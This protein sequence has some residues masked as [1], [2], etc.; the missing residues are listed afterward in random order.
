MRKSEWRDVG[1]LDLKTV[2]YISATLLGIAII[3]FVIASFTYAR[4][5][6]N[7]QVG[8]LKTNIVEEANKISEEKEKIYVDIEDL[9]DENK[10]E[11]EKKV[12]VNTSKAEEKV[13]QEKEEKPETKAEVKTE[14]KQEP[15]KEEVQEQKKE[16]VA[17]NT[18]PEVLPDPKFARP[19]DGEIIKKYAKDNLVYSNTLG[20]WVTH[21]GIDIKAD[22]TTV[23]KAAEAGKV[24]NIKNDPRYGLSVVIEHNNGYKTVY[25]NLLSTEFIVEGE[26][27]NK[28]QAIGTV[29]TT[30]TFEV[31][32]DPHLHFEIVKNS[33]YIDPELYIK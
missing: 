17:T 14:I 13:Q 26:K 2:L 19:V 5:A 31:L 7:D 12:A 28:G 10:K 15:K 22:K 16:T 9:K 20:E 21:N 23:V 8:E 18:K 33:E 6:N 27:V 30:S 29:G 11:E 25:S 32:D 3:A 4:K 24:Q 1:Q